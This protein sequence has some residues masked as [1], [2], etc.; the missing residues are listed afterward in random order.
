MSLGVNKHLVLFA[1]SDWKLSLLNA[2]RSA[3]ALSVITD[4]RK[5]TRLKSTCP[6]MQQRWGQSPLALG[7]CTLGT[8]QQPCFH[9]S[10][11]YSNCCT[12]S[13]CTEAQLVLTQTFCRSTC[14]CQF[15]WKNKSEWLLPIFPKQNIQQLKNPALLSYYLIRI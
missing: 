6:C 7:F 12:A 1:V 10:S 15:F 9:G 11:L 4:D 14:T 2:S 13:V 3:V 8:W 5:W